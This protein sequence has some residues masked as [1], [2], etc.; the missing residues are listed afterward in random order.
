MFIYL[1]IHLFACVVNWIELIENQ[2]LPIETKR[3]EAKPNS[4][5]IQINFFRER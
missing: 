5:D 3:N 2:F 4:F 1:L